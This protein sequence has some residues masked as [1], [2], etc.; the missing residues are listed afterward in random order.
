[1]KQ[2]L[3]ATE[4]TTNSS[5]TSLGLWNT[6]V[7]ANVLSTFLRKTTSIKTLDLSIVFFEEALAPLQAARTL[8]ES[9]AQNI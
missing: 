7:H 5:I 4:R 6:T 9:I 2:F 3:E 1:M 8:S